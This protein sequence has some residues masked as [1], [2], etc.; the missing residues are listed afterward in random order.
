MIQDCV[1]VYL[2]QAAIYTPLEDWP[3]GGELNDPLDSRLDGDD[4]LLSKARL[5][6]L[7]VGGRLLKLR[8]GLG[9]NAYLHPLRL[10]R[11]E[12]IAC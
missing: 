12:A 1:W 5:V 2:D 7:V 9:V 4:E 3:S 6:I 8:E 11:T 10:F